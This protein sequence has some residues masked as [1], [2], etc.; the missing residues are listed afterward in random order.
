MEAPGPQRRRL[1]RRPFQSSSKLL[2]YCVAW[3]PHSCTRPR[4][5]SRQNVYLLYRSLP[6][7][8]LDSHITREQGR[9][10][11]PW[12]PAF[13][14]PVYLPLII[15]VMDLLF[16]HH[17]PFLQT[18][19]VIAILLRNICILLSCLMEDLTTRKAQRKQGSAQHSLKPYCSRIWVAHAC[20]KGLG[21]TL[22]WAH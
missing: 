13:S 21:E 18:T 4:Q 15:Y 1:G 22:R 3:R 19:N 17:R 8:T 9:Q 14:V 10:Q 16:R 2:W 11:L 6:L 20:P 7:S 5:V 12:P